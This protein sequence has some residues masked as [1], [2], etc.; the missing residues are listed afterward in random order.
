[1]PTA[2][3]LR[4]LL[5]Q[6]RPTS[7]LNLLPPDTPAELAIYRT[8]A[9]LA[10]DRLKEASEYLDPLVP[11]MQGDD[12]SRAERLWAEIL[13]QQGWVDGSIL[14]AE[15]AA[16]AAANDEP[17]A[18]AHA[19]AAIGYARKRCF[20]LA[21]NALNNAHR[22]ASPGAWP[23]IYLAEARVRL[24]A[25]ERLEARAIYERLAQLEPVHARFSAAWGRAHVAWLLGQFDEA[26]AFA[27]DALSLSPEAIG[28]LFT[29]GQV[30]LS[31]ND[32]AGYEA[33]IAELSRRSPTA[34]SLSYWQAELPRFKA[35]LAPAT[36]GARHRLKAFPTTVQRRDYCGPCTIELVLRY[37]Q[38]ALDLNNDRIAEV[39]KIP[40][41]G[42]PT[43][44]MREF[45]HLVGFDTVRCLTTTQQ[46]KALV[47]AGYPLIVQHEYAQSSHVAVVIGYDDAPPTPEGQ[48]PVPVI[49]LQDPMTHA[50]TPMSVEEFE[51]RRQLYLA[52]AIV[53]FPRGQGHDHVLGRLELFDEP[54]VV[55]TDQ[56]GLALDEGRSNVAAELMARATAKRPDYQMAWLLWLSA[57]AN[58][59]DAAR[60]TTPPATPV[61]SL[62]AK[63]VAAQAETTEAARE[64][65]MTV[66]TQARGHHPNAEFL[67]RSAGDA[68]WNENEFTQAAEAYAGACAADEEDAYNYASLAASHY[69][70]REMDKAQDAAIKARNRMAS[71]PGANVWM[72]L[73]M[74]V[75]NQSN[76]YHYARCARE[77][78]PNWWRT[79]HA[80]A[81]VMLL[82]NNDAE[83]RPAVDAALALAPNEP[84]L[85]ALR[86]ELLSRNGDYVAAML[87]FESLLKRPNLPRVAL[88]DIYRELCRL[89]FG[90]RLFAEAAKQVQKLLTHFPDDSWALQFLAAARCQSAIQSGKHGPA[91]LADLQT[92]Y[93]RG[94][95]ACQGAYWVARDY[96]DYFSQLAGPAKGAEIATQVCAAYP[97]AA[98]FSYLRAQALARAGK[99][100]EAAQAFI[101]ALSRDGGVSNHDELY[102]TIYHIIEG[103]GPEEGEKA[104]LTAP[105]P[106]QG[107]TLEARSRM[108]A[109]V[110]ALQPAGTPAALRARESLQELLTR[111]PDDAWVTLRL[112][113]VAAA[114]GDREALYRR[115]LLLSPRWSYARGRLADY[116]TDAN[117]PAEALEFTDGHEHESFDLMA[118]HGRALL[119]TGRS[120]EAVVALTQAT[121][122][123]SSPAS[124]L[125]Y[126]KWLAESNCGRHAEALATAQSALTLFTDIP[127]WHVRAAASL[128]QLERLDEAEAQIA[129]GQ[130]DGLSEVEVCEAEYEIAWAR[131][132]WASALGITER[133]I[134]LLKEDAT[135]AALGYWEARRLRLLLTL[136]KTDAA[137]A[138][139]NAASLDATGWGEAAWT[140]MLAREWA[141]CLEFADRAL[142]L[143]AQLFTGLLARAEALLGLDREPEALTAY[144]ALRVAHPNEHNAYEKLA[145]YFA[146]DN[147]LEEA[148]TLA[149]RAVVLGP[150]C[151]FAWAARG[152]V[153]FLR[154]QREA[155]LS[156]LQAAWG[157]ADLDRRRQSNEFWW[158]LAALQRHKA[159]ARTRKAAAEKEATTAYGKR[160]VAQIE[161][162]LTDEKRTSG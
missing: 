44:R 62:A 149:E 138:W 95:S 88:Y 36:A 69:V 92:L 31:T 60:R 11:H 21:Q 29:L 9:L 100:T 84:E 111:E 113:D 127:L 79:H 142:A 140:A 144:E 160:M 152:Y 1:M 134:L 91:L 86:A 55:W 106:P 23:L 135:D 52:S 75:Q 128:R 57:E 7:V 119:Y 10:L 73:A 4:A 6:C 3:E 54:V 105:C 131:K 66:L 82:Q 99:K 48:T 32:L 38:G 24:E 51:G 126:Y 41:G 132:N 109:L 94:L 65:F 12:F 61:K 101:E 30:A 116:L 2:P 17:R 123:A 59:W 43:Y 13:L 14:S 159:L 130:A 63:L 154:G 53:A 5:D 122:W 49:E 103:L 96:V 78:A 19:W 80:W 15:G 158:L 50:I 155:A 120:E 161:K 125:H 45:F 85:L 64:R 22:F 8:E 40:G 124:W 77:L 27:Q 83:A 56:A 143:D 162:A 121:Q 58:R 156:D 34:E 26:R 46:V 153:H 33:V 90:S 145:L 137:W 98:A 70:L 20:N 129:Q 107:P 89:L 114:E 87:E 117:R 146:V 133:L 115:A 72:A 42:T 148:L 16:N 110:L 118:A 18:V 37:W 112:G 35:R 108:V 68:A 67:H 136:G 139:L 47:D 102:E 157:R 71:L 39:V 81:R 141:L 97:D 147:R 76:A 28:P 151:P 74:A 25:D 93:N 104:A 150:F